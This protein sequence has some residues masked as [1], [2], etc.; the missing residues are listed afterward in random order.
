[1]LSCVRQSACAREG[2]VSKHHH[3]DILSGEN[4]TCRD[5]PATRLDLLGLIIFSAGLFSVTFALIAGNQHGW[6]TQRVRVAFVAAAVLAVVFVIAELKQERPML[7]MS[8][9]GHPT[10]IGA[11][12]A[13]LALAACNVT[14][15]TYLPLYFQSAL[16]CSPQSAE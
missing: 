15:L 16:G 2:L 14:M 6:G 12:V 3:R 4:G 7:D 9:F 1:L 8:C 11:A 13:T 10:Y 5:P